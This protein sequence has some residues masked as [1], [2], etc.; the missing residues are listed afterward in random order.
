M[1]QIVFKKQKKKKKSSKFGF[2]SEKRK[3]CAQN[4]PFYFVCLAFSQNFAQKKKPL[5]GLCVAPRRS[6]Q[7]F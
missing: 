1:W 6:F 7:F 4:I 5:L 3:C 2:F